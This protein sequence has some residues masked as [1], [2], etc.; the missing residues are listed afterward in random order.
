MKYTHQYEKSLILTN[1][2]KIKLT[3]ILLFL[4]ILSSV[5]LALAQQDHPKIYINEFMASN[6]STALSYDFTE[7]ADW[8]EI[9]NA[10]DTSVNIGGFY[11]SDD[12]SDPQKW[13]IPSGTMIRSGRRA[14]F[15]ADGYDQDKHTNFKLSATGEEIGLFT[16]EGVLIDSIRFPQQYPDISYGRSP[17][18]GEQWL[19]FEQATPGTSNKY[20]GF[21][22][23]LPKLTFS[24]E[25]GLF[26]G[27]LSVEIAHPYP[28][29]MIRYTL[30]GSLPDSQSTLYSDEILVNAT[31]VIRARAFQE[32]YLPSNVIT[33]T[34]FINESTTLPLVSVST[35][36]ENLWDDEIGIYVAGTNGISGYCSSEPKNWNQAWERKIN[37][38]LYENS[39]EQAFNIEA[40]MQIGGGCT[41]KYP[42]K[43]L[44][45]YVRSEY[46]TSKIEYP[47]FSDKNIS[48]FNNILLRNNGQDWWRG[49]FR[50]GLMHTIVKNKMD[51]DWQAYRPSVLFLNGEY[52]GI[53]G[54]REKHNEHYLENNYGIDPDAIDILSGNANIKQ[55]SSSMYTNMIS[56]IENHDMANNTYYAWVETQM[57]INEYQNYIIAEIY[58]ANIDWPGGNIKY[59]RQQGEGHKWRW[60][61]FDTDLGFGAHEMGQY[62]SNSL[63]NATSPEKTYYANSTWSTFL[64]RSLLKNDG[65]RN[66]FVQRFAT[67]MNFTFD[68]SRVL[69]IIDSLKANIEAEMPRHIQKWSESTSFNNGWAYH[70]DVMKEFATLRPEYA[71]DHLINKFGLSGTAQLH[72]SNNDSTMGSVYVQDID[73]CKENVE[74]IF[75]KDIPLECTAVA[76]PGYKF[77]GWQG[78]VQSDSASI[79][80]VLNGESYLSAVFQPDESF[81]FHGL[82]IN[83]LLAQNTQVISDE[84]GEYDDWIEIY[85]HSRD[86]IDIGGMYVTD[87]FQEPKMWQIPINEPERTTIPPGGFLLLWA[88]G[89]TDQGVLHLDL[90]LSADGEEF[91]IGRETDSGFVF[92]DTLSFGAQ[93]A[94]VSYGRTPDGDAK[95]TYFTSPTP[96]YSNVI[97][98]SIENDI[99]L[100][101]EFVLNQNYPNPFN[102]TTTISYRIGSIADVEL[103]IFDMSGKKVTTL[104][105]EVQAT[106]SYKLIWDASNLASGIYFYRLQAG[107]YIDTKKMILMK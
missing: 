24:V 80:I 89:D 15:W 46:G 62:N 41:R 13:Q 77:I 88:D 23:R 61:L 95:L 71:I 20:S 27:D 67:H 40:G 6:S 74:G 49:M 99:I 58:F 68:P 83:E 10:E 16:S 1:D 56:Y 19:Y 75:F 59:W 53:H 45:I 17:D 92:L 106:G 44:A 73:I 28:F 22:G 47:I 100:P 103:S 57:D 42:Q 5:H 85:N 54:I 9:H 37:L 4:W 66:Q 38:E 90:K 105:R 25:G 2:M 31:S 43:T 36:P 32:N 7:Y 70:V 93:L 18:A 26:Q 64:L 34:Y 107:T 39:G 69:G 91:G 97:E 21:S 79:K 63:E 65:F 86:A 51:I 50:D 87:N 94:D 30:D 104:V 82:R 29:A 98:N 33:Q 76:N 60:I 3:N 96:G 102:P 11:L 81:V 12:L 84:H 48:T 8:I 35:N 78:L 52:W 14:L 101:E 72:I 55:G